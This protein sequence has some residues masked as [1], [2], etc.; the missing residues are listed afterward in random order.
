[1]GWRFRVRLHTVT[2]IHE[3]YALLQSVE[4]DP[5][6]FLVRALPKPSI[7]QPSIRLDKGTW[8]RRRKSGED[9][10]FMATPQP[11]LCADFDKIALPLGLDPLQDL[12]AVIAWLLAQLP[13]EL[14]GVTCVVQTSSSYGLRQDV[15][16]FHLWYWLN[17]GMG[18]DEL[19]RW[20]VISFLDDL[21]LDIAC[22]RDVQPLYVARP[23]FRGVPDPLPSSRLRLIEGV[24]DVAVLPD[25]PAVEA[26]VE[27]IARRR[28][29]P[30]EKVV[31]DLS[32]LPVGWRAK[33]AA[34]GDGEGRFGFHAPLLSASAAYVAAHGADA[35]E[36]TFKAAARAAIAGA[37]KGQGRK[38]DLERYGSD[39]YL[40]TL[41][42]SAKN[43]ACRG[44]L[45][46][47]SA[48]AELDP[49]ETPLI[50]APV[51]LPLGEARARV[52]SL[53]DEAFGRIADYHARQGMGAVGLHDEPPQLLIEAGVGVG[54][55]AAAID[56]LVR[57]LD[58]SPR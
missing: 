36:E 32:D 28:G 22:L 24:R 50:E 20:A 51:L 58:D 35:D 46:R 21:P 7:R 19:K 2:G 54:K 17:R 53:I 44:E 23:A 40:D 8:L 11:W 9:A 42:T 18:Y 4:A 38:G 10:P 31:L 16:S 37:P 52:V 25:P 39:T 41:L 14:R 26:R 33:L 49:D 57:Y 34:M 43:K 15:V 47:P 56:A 45:G 5:Y 48:L 13:P 6:A 1:M 55:S 12:D 27:K 30:R 29:V 3:L